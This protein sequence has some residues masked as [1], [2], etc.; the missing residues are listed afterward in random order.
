MKIREEEDDDEKMNNK[1]SNCEYFYFP[2]LFAK[3]Y[4]KTNLSETKWEMQKY[5]ILFWVEISFYLYT[6]V[7]I[8]TE[9]TFIFFL[10]KL[11]NKNE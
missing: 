10:L 6:S 8:F 7:W 3:R 2:I 11:L 5:T 4:F 1:S 9:I